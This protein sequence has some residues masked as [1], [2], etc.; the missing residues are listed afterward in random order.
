LEF[1]RD[2][3]RQVRHADSLEAALGERSKRQAVVVIGNAR[4]SVRLGRK[5]GAGLA[6]GSNRDRSSGGVVDIALDADRAESV[7]IVAEAPWNRELW[8]H[9]EAEPI[10]ARGAV[11]VDRLGIVVEK[12]EAVGDIAAAAQQQFRKLLQ[13]ELIGLDEV[14]MPGALELRVPVVE[15]VEQSPM[16]DRIA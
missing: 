8:G 11:E 6:D 3:R 14:L 15:F 7:E 12:G 9:R 4:R 10:L 2:P 5:R 13:G 16:G 1:G